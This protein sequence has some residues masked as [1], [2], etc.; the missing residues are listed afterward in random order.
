MVARHRA[1]PRQRTGPSFG[2]ENEGNLSPAVR[3]LRTPLPASDPPFGRS[4][5]GPRTASRT[6][7][8][9]EQL[10]A[11]TVLLPCEHSPVLGRLDVAAALHEALTALA[12]GGGSR[13]ASTLPSRSIQFSSSARSAAKSCHLDCEV[14]T[15]ESLLRRTNS[16]FFSLTLPRSIPQTRLAS[17]KRSSLRP[18]I[19]SRVVTSVRLPTK[20]SS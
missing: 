16:G 14:P 3:R 5:L 18:M 7:V 8:D 10:Y 19:S 4:G 12:I 13:R 17:P 2:L 11:Q 6:S 1:A 15:R 20:P 9:L